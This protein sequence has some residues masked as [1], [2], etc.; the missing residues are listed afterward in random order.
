MEIMHINV[1]VSRVN[2]AWSLKVSR[3]DRGIFKL[4]KFIPR[5]KVLRSAIHAETYRH[6]RSGDWLPGTEIKLKPSTGI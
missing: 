4:P 6:V 2:N 5:K 3:R 1:R